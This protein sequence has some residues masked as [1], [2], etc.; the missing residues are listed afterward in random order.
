MLGENTDNGYKQK[1]TEQSTGHW[2]IRCRRRTSACYRP[3]SA[4]LHWCSWVR[5]WWSRKWG[6]NTVQEEDNIV[7]FQV[8]DCHSPK[9]SFENDQNHYRCS[10]RCLD[11]GSVYLYLYITET[12]RWNVERTKDWPGAWGAKEWHDD[13]P[14]L[15]F[16]LVCSRLGGEEPNN[17]EMPQYWSELPFPAPGDLPDPGIEPT[18]LGS[19]ALAGGFFLPLGHLGSPQTKTPPNKLL[20]TAK[21]LERVILARQKTFRQ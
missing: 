21:G 18:S 9:S 5:R 4:T 13:C 16:C 10:V 11:R 15:S 6:V 7:F 17:L 14:G 2:K 20:L 12:E 19:P 8:C 3:H 1:P